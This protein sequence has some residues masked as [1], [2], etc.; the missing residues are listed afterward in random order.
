MADSAHL[1]ASRPP[2]PEP[3]PEGRADQCAC[4]CNRERN[5]VR[6]AAAIVPERD[7]D[8]DTE[9]ETDKRPEDATEHSHL[10]EGCAPRPLL[11]RRPLPYYEATV[12]VQ[13]VSLFPS[14][15]LER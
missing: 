8:H 5:R 4:G 2:S 10:T 6:P 7:L 1:R 11:A 3:P 14:G 12:N 9:D 15:P 13:V